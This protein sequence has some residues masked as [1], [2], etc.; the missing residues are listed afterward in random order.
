ME[1]YDATELVSERKPWAEI[2]RRQGDVGGTALLGASREGDDA[3]AARVGFDV[4]V[5][6]RVRDL[7]EDGGFFR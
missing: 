7:E 3:V 4:Q 6:W 5:R 2:G 1:R